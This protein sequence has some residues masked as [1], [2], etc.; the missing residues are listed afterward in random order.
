MIKRVNH[1][2]IVVKSVDDTLKFFGEVFGFKVQHIETVPDQG[3]RT[4]FVMVG[5]TAIE[6][7]EP[8]DPN[9]GVARFLATRGEGVHHIS[10]ETSDIDAEL[11]RLES[12]G[13]AL[14]DRKGKPGT[15]GKVGFVHPKATKGILFELVQKV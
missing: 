8:T 2:G 1:V 7:F 10:L 4:A 3:V 9:G 14:I 6:F 5:D 11:A 13:I 15:A 12:K